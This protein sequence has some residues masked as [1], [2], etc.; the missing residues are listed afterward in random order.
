MSVENCDYPARAIKCEDLIIH[1]V[2]AVCESFIVLNESYWKSSLQ[3][4]SFALSTLIW[5]RRA[6]PCLQQSFQTKLSIRPSSIFQTSCL[7]VVVLQNKHRFA[8][9]DL[10][11]PLISACWQVLGLQH[12]WIL[13][14]VHEHYSLILQISHVQLRFPEMLVPSYV[15]AFAGQAVTH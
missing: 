8:W 6:A 7:C 12:M 4:E 2:I 15:W 11:N 1:Y 3:R 14:V 13:V 10:I 5:I 9:C